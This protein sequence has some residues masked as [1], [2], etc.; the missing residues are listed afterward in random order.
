MGVN[1]WLKP[2]KFSISIFIFLVTSIYIL[3]ELPYSPI[4]LNI[5]AWTLIGTMAVE[6]ICIYF[7]AFRGVQSH[8]NVSSAFNGMIFATMGIMISTAYFAYLIILIDFFRLETTVSPAMLWAIRIGIIILLFGGISGFMMAS[9][10]KHNIGVDDGG[11]G[12]PFTN[13]STVGG[14]LRVSHFISLH[15]LQALPLLVILLTKFQISSSQQLLSV[16]TIGVLYASFAVFT[17]IQ[18]INGQPFIRLE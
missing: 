3:A 8:F 11:I 13:W 16:I 10:L 5:I 12:L 4:K 15:A 14:D 17:L 6:L 1:I 7:Q 2:L 18:A 9:G